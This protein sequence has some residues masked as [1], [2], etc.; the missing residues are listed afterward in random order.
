MDDLLEIGGLSFAPG[1]R[2]VV[3]LDCGRDILHKVID[4]EVH[5]F[6]GREPGPC[7]FVSA[8]V[9]GDEINGVEICRRLLKS[10]QLKKLKGDLIV[11]PIVNV[12]AFVAR[13]RYLPDRRDLNRLFPGSDDGSFGSRIAKLFT[14]E[15]VSKCDY[16]I[17]LHTGASNRTNLPQVR[18]QMHIDGNRE[19]A[20]AFGAPVVLGANAPPEGSLRAVCNDMN[21]RVMVYEAGESMR[22][23]APSVRYGLNGVFHVMRHLEMIPSMKRVSKPPRTSFS[24]RSFWVRA[25]VGGIFRAMTPL[26]KAVSANSKLGVVGD[27]LGP[28][29]VTVFPREEG[30]VIGRTNQATVDE[31]DA[32]FHI[33]IS[34]DVEKAEERITKSGEAVMS[35]AEPALYHDSVID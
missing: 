27:P 6:R 32:L 19:L 8:G 33:A 16:G 31:G 12:P 5:V 23:D 30:I 4:F 14:S 9:H 11:T 35:D 10:R 18:M 15:I 34:G 22:L 2:G 1:S 20:G 28:N 29:E 3:R 13:S 7:L 26:G 24:T 17:D 25:P 21:V